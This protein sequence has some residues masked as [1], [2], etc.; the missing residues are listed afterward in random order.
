M[1]ITVYHVQECAGEDGL[2]FWTCEPVS[3]EE[4]CLK[5]MIIDTK[6]LKE[7]MIKGEWF[8][9]TDIDF[10][11]MELHDLLKEARK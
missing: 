1:E 7:G 11:K 4:I 6:D 3:R 5:E 8:N 10:I 2:V 9:Q